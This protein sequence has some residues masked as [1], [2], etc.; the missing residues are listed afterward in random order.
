MKDTLQATPRAAAPLRRVGNALSGPDEFDPAL[1][2]LLRDCAV[3]ETQLLYDLDDDPAL[4]QLRCGVDN[5]TRS[6]TLW[7]IVPRVAPEVAQ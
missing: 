7:F 3:T 6:V 2:D 5:D 1:F 4:A